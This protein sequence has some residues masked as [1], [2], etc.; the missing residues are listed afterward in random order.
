MN[1]FTQLLQHGQDVMQGHGWN[2]KFFFFSTGCLS[3]A[4]E[5]ILSYLPTA[6]FMLFPRALAQSENTNSFIQDLNSDKI[7]RCIHSTYSNY[8]LQSYLIYYLLIP[9]VL[10]FMP[11]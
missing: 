9:S 10:A 4:K 3:K 5:P 2:S 1:L 7:L 11:W 6:G 8:M